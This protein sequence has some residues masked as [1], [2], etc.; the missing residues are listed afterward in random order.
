MSPSTPPPTVHGTNLSP[1]TQ[2]A[3]WHSPL[4]IIAIKH[5]CCK[6]FYA[7]VSCH[8]EGERH[9]SVPWPSSVWGRKG[10]YAR[11]GREA[12]GEGDEQE[13]HRGE[14]EENEGQEEYEV[15]E[16]VEGVVL[17]GKCKHSMGVGEYLGCES[18]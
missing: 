1:T 18:R 7:C 8:D 5:F 10:K 15:E 12:G 16:E 6:K 2:C 4:D 3:H 13:G 9:G 11:I 14:D 17:C